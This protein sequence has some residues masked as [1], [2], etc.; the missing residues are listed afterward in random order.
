MIHHKLPAFFSLSPVPSVGPSVIPFAFSL[1]DHISLF[2]FSCRP[3]LGA[4]NS[5]ANMNRPHFGQSISQQG[6]FSVSRDS[7][8]PPCA[9]RTAHAHVSATAS[10]MDLTRRNRRMKERGRLKSGDQPLL[11]SWTRS[12]T[13]GSTANT[14]ATN[15]SSNHLSGAPNIAGGCNG[16][17]R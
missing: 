12:G 13:R 5:K 9:T 16:T 8:S 6:F 7:I 3:T 11:D 15:A 10:E 17:D 1:T 2:S 4:I 14:L